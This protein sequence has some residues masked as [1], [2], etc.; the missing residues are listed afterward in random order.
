MSNDKLS[1]K[2]III[3]NKLSNAGIIKT[4]IE[5]GKITN[6]KIGIKSY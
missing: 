4:I 1:V 2:L 6:K 3:Y 5:N